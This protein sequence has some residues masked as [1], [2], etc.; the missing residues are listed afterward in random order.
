MLQY[1]NSAFY[2]FALST[3]SF[4][5]IPCEFAWRKGA[6]PRDKN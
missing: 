1:D 4:Y 5:I 2:F 6:L 3:I